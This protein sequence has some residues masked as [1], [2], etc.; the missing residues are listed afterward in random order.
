MVHI[1]DAYT[2]VPERGWMVERRPPAIFA[3]FD[4][5]RRAA[6]V[7]VV[8]DVDADGPVRRADE[9]VVLDRILGPQVVGAMDAAFGGFKGLS[10]GVLAD[11]SAPVLDRDRALRDDVV[12]VP[13][14]VV[15]RAG[16]FADRRPENS[17]HQL[18]GTTLQ[19]DVLAEGVL[20]EHDDGG[21]GGRAAD[22]ND[23]DSHRD[24]AHHS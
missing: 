13:R 2:L 23:R 7:L 5:A 20:P 18:S 19:S 12:D 16:S 9:H 1:R 15:P 6:P 11:L 3:F 22:G 4:R 17:G 8:R 14:M 21:V 24:D 10:L